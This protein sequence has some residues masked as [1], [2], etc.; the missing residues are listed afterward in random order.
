MMAC[1]AMNFKED[2]LNLKDFIPLVLDTSIKIIDIDAGTGRIA[3]PPK[4]TTK[5]NQWLSCQATFIKI[6]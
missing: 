3:S 4:D 5:Y 6:L 1:F 2:T